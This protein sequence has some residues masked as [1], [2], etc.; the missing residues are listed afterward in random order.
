MGREVGQR[1]LAAGADAER[2]AGGLE[3]AADASHAAGPGVAAQGVDHGAADAALG[4]GLEAD[5]PAFVVPVHGVDEA[6]HPVLHQVADVH[7]GGH[8]GGHSTGKGLDERPAGDHATLLVFTKGLQH[9]SLLS[10]RCRLGSR[11]DRACTGAV[12][13]WSNDGAK[14]MT[15]GAYWG[16]LMLSA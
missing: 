4:E 10:T 13:T 16:C 2:L 15:G 7:A 12:H 1:G 14:L 9:V 8:R 11:L 3:L 5:A 6:N